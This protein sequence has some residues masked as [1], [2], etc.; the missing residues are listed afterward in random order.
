MWLEFEQT[1]EEVDV[2]AILGLGHGGVGMDLSIQGIRTRPSHSGVAKPRR[3]RQGRSCPSI[4][5][6]GEKQFCRLSF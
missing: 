5:V 6:T 2:S 4:F 1:C 3:A